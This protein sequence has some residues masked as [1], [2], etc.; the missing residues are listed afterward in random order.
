MTIKSTQRVITA[1]HDINLMSEQQWIMMIM[2]WNCTLVNLAPYRPLHWAVPRCHLAV[3]GRLPPRVPLHRQAPATS[4]FIKDSSAVSCV[5]YYQ[6]LSINLKAPA[7]Q[8]RLTAAVRF[9]K[10]KARF[11]ETH[12]TNTHRQN[13][14]TLP[15]IHSALMST[16]TDNLQII[17][18][19]S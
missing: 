14:F 16:A 19:R 18:A 10:A 3:T 15:P 13:H 9:T 2:L 12:K 11:V 7:G 4:I 8:P 1:G 6:C 17:H 5:C